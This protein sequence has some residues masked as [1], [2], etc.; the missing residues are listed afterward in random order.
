MAGPLP[1]FALARPEPGEATNR[2][3]DHRSTRLVF[4]C[5]SCTAIAPNHTRDHTGKAFEVRCHGDRERVPFSWI[6]AN[7]DKLHRIRRDDGPRTALIGCLVVPVPF[8]HP[9][10]EEAIRVMRAHGKKPPGQARSTLEGAPE[11][12]DS[13]PLWVGVDQPGLHE[14]HMGVDLGHDDVG[15]LMC[16]WCVSTF[17]D[18]ESAAKE[19]CSEAPRRLTETTWDDFR[20]HAARVA[21]GDVIAG[22]GWWL[23]ARERNMSEPARRGLD[24]R[25]DFFQPPI[26][27]VR[28]PQAPCPEDRPDD[29]RH[30]HCRCGGTKL[31][32]KPP[33]DYVPPLQLRDQRIKDMNRRGIPTGITLPEPQPYA[34]DVHID[35]RVAQQAQQ[36]ADALAHAMQTTAR[37]GRRVGRTSAD[38]TSQ[39]WLARERRAGHALCWNCGHGLHAHANGGGTCTACGC[40]RVLRNA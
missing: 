10:V 26:P 39:A 11:C 29:P 9:V 35:V 15:D 1:G 24:V 4:F 6:D 8:E 22:A 31:D 30:V 27:G 32:E 38:M 18:N 21:P 25:W 7:L 36:Q 13:E 3:T 16:R 33:A 2:I 14:L 28:I 40:S 12:D 17:R 20:K 37:A 23:V 34:R 5:T 19:Q